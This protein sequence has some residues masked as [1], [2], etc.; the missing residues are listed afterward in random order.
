MGMSKLK[1]KI[2]ARCNTSLA[3]TEY[4]LYANGSPRNVCKK[5][6]SAILQEGR[7]KHREARIVKNGWSPGD[8]RLCACGCGKPVTKNFDKLGNFKNYSDYVKGHYK[9]LVMKKAESISQSSKTCP[10]CN[11]LKVA[12]DY[13]RRHDRHGYKLSSY[14]KS[15]SKEVEKEDKFRHPEKHRAR[16]KK[17]ALKN[18]FGISLEEYYAISAMQNNVCAGCGGVDLDGRALA[19]DHKHNEDGAI[20]GLLCSM[21]NQGIGLL[22]D[23]PIILRKLAD[24]IESVQ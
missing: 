20:R 22:K 10:R 13:Y 3:I 18:S 17:I 16:S 19:V 7:I 21:C 15:C 6:N 4:W 12:S 9:L 5:C 2:C 14:C 24:Y 8:V 11:V 1:E 23:D